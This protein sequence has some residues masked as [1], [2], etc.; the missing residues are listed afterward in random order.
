M[1]GIS[2]IIPLL[3]T[4]QVTLRF[5]RWDNADDVKNLDGKP[6]SILETRVREL[7]DRN[8]SQ[9]GVLPGE[10]LLQSPMSSFPDRVTEGLILWKRIL[11]HFYRK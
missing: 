4:E 5:Y 10:L 11:V 6:T 8:Q 2:A 1:T 3:K 7:Q 9:V